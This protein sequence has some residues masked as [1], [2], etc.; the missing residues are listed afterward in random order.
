[1]YLYIIN[2]YVYIHIYIY[3][4]R[5]WR[6]VDGTKSVYVGILLIN[7]LLCRCWHFDSAFLKRKQHSAHK[8]RFIMYKGK[9]YI[10]TAHK[11][12]ETIRFDVYQLIPANEFD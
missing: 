3:V 9:L 6:N 4:Y 1:M 7:T 8:S 10:S 2:K 12:F 5:T 11:G